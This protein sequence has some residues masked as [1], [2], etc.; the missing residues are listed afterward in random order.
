MLKSE[1][2]TGTQHFVSVIVN[3]MAWFD[4]VSSNTEHFFGHCYN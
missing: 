2:T 1:I 4:A 3:F